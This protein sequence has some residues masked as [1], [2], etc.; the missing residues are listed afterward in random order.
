MKNLLIFSS[1][2]I[3]DEIKKDVD[4]FVKTK[5]IGYIPASY[6]DNGVKSANSF[7]YWDM[8][9]K[10]YLPF[11]VGKYFDESILEDLKECDAIHLGGGNTFEFLLMLKHRGMIEF[12]REYVKNG[13]LLMGTSAG[14]IMMCPSVQIAQFA[15]ENFIFMHETQMGGLNLVD[16]DVKPHWDVW[17]DFRLNFERFSDATRRKIYC[18][19]EGQAIFV[20]DDKMKFYGGQPD[21]VVP[22]D[23]SK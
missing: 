23:E 3:T 22:K 7:E 4:P 10:T 6:W 15:D 9:F 18:L 1:M 19:C 12:L 11:P 21:L 13:G 14:G 5:C 2:Y 8:G 17:K 20:Q 16:F